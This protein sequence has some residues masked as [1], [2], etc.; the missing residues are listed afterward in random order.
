MTRISCKE[1]INILNQGLKNV[2]KNHLCGNYLRLNSVDTQWGINNR[3]YCHKIWIDV[4]KSVGEFDK[5]IE[6]KYNYD[7]SFNN[8]LCKLYETA[9]E[10]TYNK[11]GFME[12]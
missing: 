4:Y 10:Y 6:I 1:K 7:E 3:P 11:Y 8:N 2:L 5:R 9:Q 12:D